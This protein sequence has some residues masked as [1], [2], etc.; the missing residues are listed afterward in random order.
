MC[1]NSVVLPISL[2]VSLFDGLHDPSSYMTELMEQ[3]QWMN[4]R[5]RHPTPPPPPW[6]RSESCRYNFNCLTGHSIQHPLRFRPGM[7]IHCGACDGSWFLARNPA[8][9]NRDTISWRWVFPLENTH[10]PGATLKAWRYER[11][12]AEVKA[13]RNT[14]FMVCHFSGMTP[15]SEV[16]GGLINA[17]NMRWRSHLGMILH[18]TGHSS[19][20]ALMSSLMCGSAAGS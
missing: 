2:C 14:V 20:K 7:E 16:N 11:R 5:C 4:N 15:I 13:N 12:L 19:R 3:F 17:K 1:C 9:S 8:P 18:C 6:I 10:L